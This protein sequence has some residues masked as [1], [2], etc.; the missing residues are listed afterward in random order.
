MK[1]GISNDLLNGTKKIGVWGI[2]YIGITNVIHFSESGV[3]SICF[4]ISKNVVEDINQGIVRI[5]NLESWMGQQLRPFVDRGL[6]K[7]TTDFNE[8]KDCPIHFIAVPTEKDEKPWL[9][10]IKDVLK[11][12]KSFGDNRLIVIESTLTPGTVDTLTIE[13]D[14]KNPIAI[15]PRRDWF[16]SPEMNLRNLPRVFGVNNVEYTE[17]FKN[18][19]SIVCNTLLVASNHKVAEMVKSVENSLLHVPVAYA[20]EVARAYPNINISEV[21]DL[22]S[23]HWRIPKYNI[24]FGTGG[25]CIPLSTQ[26]VI[27][28]AEKPQELKIAKGAIESDQYQPKY[29][30]KHIKG[31]NIGILGICYKG[32]LKVCILSPSL[33]IVDELH[34]NNSGGFAIKIFDPYYSTDEIKKIAR[35]DSFTFPEDLEHFSTIILGPTHKLFKQITREEIKKYIKPG[36]RILDSQGCWGNHRQ[37]FIELGIEYMRVGDGSGHWN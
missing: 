27:A 4:D 34:N 10:A 2:G 14:L 33:K 16:Q 37:Q 5:P 22:A 9:D 31:K 6:I 3:K 13:L 32:D 36:T 19:L 7:A 30:S 12:I 11:K 1:M 35:C 15:A 26:Y 21:F 24:T 20:M 8:L 28:G 17:E 25:Y 18:V 29:V 23:T